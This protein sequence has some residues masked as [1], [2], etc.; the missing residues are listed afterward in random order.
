MYVAVVFNSPTM[1]HAK[2]R[3]AKNKYD[4]TRWRIGVFRDGP[5]LSGVVDTSIAVAKVFKDTYTPKI[6]IV[7]D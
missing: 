5:T 6:F 3:Y 1:E 2:Q 7:K 4:S